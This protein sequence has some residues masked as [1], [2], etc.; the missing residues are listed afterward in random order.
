MVMVMRIAKAPGG[1]APNQ[2]DARVQSFS[3]NK[4][5]GGDIYIAPQSDILDYEISL[6]K[7]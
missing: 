4:L 6:V 5:A 1:E 3:I 7:S 2:R